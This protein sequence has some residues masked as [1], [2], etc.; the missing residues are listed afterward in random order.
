MVI[1]FPPSAEGCFELKISSEAQTRVLE[2]ASSFGVT[3]T[4]CFTGGNVTPIFDMVVGGGLNDGAGSAAPIQST[5]VFSGGLTYKDPADDLGDG[6]TRSPDFSS[7]MM[8]Q[9]I[10]HLRVLPSLNGEENLVIVPWGG[11]YLVEQTVDGVTSTVPAPWSKTSIDIA[12]YK[13]QDNY[14]IPKYVN[15]NSE[16][17][18]FTDGL[19]A[20]ESA[21]KTTM[22][23]TLMGNT[24]EVNPTNGRVKSG[25]LFNGFTT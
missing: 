8:R 3:Y 7:Q 15:E 20:V 17:A 4:A 21:Y 22:N 14:E 12:E 11:Y 6:I 16:P 10:F 1:K 19:T 23:P 5:F 25:L 18:T 9:K 13:I 2:G 24:L